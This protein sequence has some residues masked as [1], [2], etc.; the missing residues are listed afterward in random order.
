MKLKVYKNN[1]LVNEFNE[2]HAI[3]AFLQALANKAIH[4]ANITLR[5]K[6]N[7]SLYQTVTEIIKQD[8]LEGIVTYKYEYVD[9][10]ISHGQIDVNKILEE[11]MEYYET[12]ESVY[13]KER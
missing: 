5:Y 4:K 1:E 12:V 7:Y 2:G 8:T 6:N 10:P 11:Y 13:I 3:R 9:V